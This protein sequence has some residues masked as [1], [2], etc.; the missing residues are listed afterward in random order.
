MAARTLLIALTMVLLLTAPRVPAEGT[1]QSIFLTRAEGTLVV[2]AQGQV[3][4]LAMKTKLDPLLA[5]AVERG[6]RAMRFKPV[7]VGGVATAARAA[8]TVQLVGEKIGDGLR[9]S[10]DGISFSAPGGRTDDVDEGAMSA[11]RMAPPTYPGDMLRDGTMGEVQLAMLVTP[12][13]RLADVAVVRSTLYGSRPRAS[14]AVAMRQFERASL[15]AARKWTFN[16]PPALGN[17]PAK[18]RTGTTRVVFLINRSGPEIA[19]PGQWV[20][21][22]REPSRPAPW[23]DGDDARKAAEQYVAGGG[24]APIGG[25]FELLRP[26]A[27]TTLQ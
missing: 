6:L 12:D 5:P 22:L 1:V 15:L 26:L 23:L 24:L 14:V 27:G 8:F 13:G 7:T 16:V 25:R 2:D 21:V 20:E 9:V 17:A 10:F 11:K 18:D 19:E 4:E 3:V